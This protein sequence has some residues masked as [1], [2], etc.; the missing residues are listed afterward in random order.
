MTVTIDATNMVLI[1]NADQTTGWTSSMGGLN[2]TTLSTR[3]GGTALQDQASQET[4]QVTHAITSEDYTGRTIFGWQKSGGPTTEADATA[5]GFSMYIR[6]SANGRAYDVGGS[7]NYAFFFSGWSNFRLNTAGLPTAYFQVVGSG[8][9]TLTALVGVGY[10]GRFPAKA[11][12]NSDNVQF[13]VLRYCDNAN[14]ALLI[15]GGTTGARG[16]WQEVATEDEST[17]NAWGVIRQLVVGSKAFEVMFGVQVGSLD[18]NSYHEDADFQLFINGALTSGGTI[19]AGSMDFTFVGWAS[20][21]NVANYDNFFIQNIGTVSNWDASDTDI[22]ELQWT[23]GQFVDMGIFTFQAQDAGSKFVNNCTWVN[24]GQVAFV[25]TDSDNCAFLGT[26]NANGAVL[27]ST[28][29][30]EVANQD[31]MTFVSDGTG[32][33]IE[34]DLNTASLTTYNVSG[35]IVDGF[36][37]QSGTAGNRVFYIDNALDGDVTINITDGEVLNSV[38]GGAGF[39]YE[40]AAGYTGTVTINQTVTLAAQVNAP[41][42]EGGAA[43]E[44]ASVRFENASGGALISQGSTNA[45]GLYSDSTYN[46]GGDLAVTI[47]VRLKGWRYFRTAGTIISTG[48]TVGV[49]LTPNKIVDLP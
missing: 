42:T 9:P 1:D 38:G 14:P 36:A 23:N 13:D 40:V 22:D 33:A 49:T 15:E 7:D 20:G 47:K 3:E 30:S 41:A 25:G 27:W 11:A 5:A 39:S 31:N 10:G 34:I 35:L 16:T 45:S 46:Y 8:A 12:G 28:T 2:T 26:T 29:A 44:G 19:T 37:G 32:H 24:C 21:T 18:A 4:Y 6:S 48:L 17:N 43:I